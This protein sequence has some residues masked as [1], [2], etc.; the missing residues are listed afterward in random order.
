MAHSE[1]VG[2]T[3]DAEQLTATVANGHIRSPFISYS[4][5]RSRQ[6]RCATNRTRCAV[7]LLSSSD[8][9]QPPARLRPPLA[10]GTSTA[11]GG[12]CAR[13][14]QSGDEHAQQSA[15]RRGS[16]RQPAGVAALLLLHICA[17]T[18]P[19]RRRDQSTP[20]HQVQLLVDGS[21][22]AKEAAASALW[23]ISQHRQVPPVLVQMCLSPC[24]HEM[25][26]A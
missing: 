20:A 8:M 16:R 4:G 14:A 5:A 1:A 18:N 12:V 3:V 25:M 7:V 13:A 26:W 17:G 15:D 21:A 10:A 19:R 23:Q 9:R 24:R 6:A 22:L 11:A 2:Q